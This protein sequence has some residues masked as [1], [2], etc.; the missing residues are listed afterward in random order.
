MKIDHKNNALK[1][2]TTIFGF[3]HFGKT[4][5]PVQIILMITKLMILPKIDSVPFSAFK[6][7]CQQRRWVKL[8]EW[9]V[10]GNI[11]KK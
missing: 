10:R 11:Q 9:H 8:L 5:L 2:G 7:F 4:V 6:S 1:K 3:A